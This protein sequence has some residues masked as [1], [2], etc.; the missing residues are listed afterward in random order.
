M[1]EMVDNHAF[2][3]LCFQHSVEEHNAGSIDHRNDDGRNSLCND[4]S[5]NRDENC[6][7]VVC[8][9]RA[10]LYARNEYFKRLFD[11]RYGFVLV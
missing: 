11:S 4:S 9:H 3:D 5:N 6:A 10:V 7:V 2:S 1:K 8:A